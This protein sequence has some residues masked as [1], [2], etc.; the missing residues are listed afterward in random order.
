[1]AALE[2]FLSL[3]DAE[4]AQMADAIARVRAMTPEQRAALRKEIMA[5]RQLP[6]QQRQH[7]RQGW[8]SMPADIQDGWREMM[9]STPPEQHAAIQAKLQSLSPA[10]KAQYRRDLV[11]AWRKTHPKK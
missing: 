4:L 6:A 5:F 11:E 2:Q 10:E 7:L 9:Q 1:M 8:G 3:S